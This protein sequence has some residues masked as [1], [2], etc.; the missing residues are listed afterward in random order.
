MVHLDFW[1]FMGSFIA[2]L[3]MLA[4]AFVHYVAMT[5]LAFLVNIVEQTSF[6]S[7]QVRVELLQKLLLQHDHL[8]HQLLEPSKTTDVALN[9]NELPF[10]L[11]DHKIEKLLKADSEL[12]EKTDS[13]YLAMRKVK[14]LFEVQGTKTSLPESNTSKSITV[15][16]PSPQ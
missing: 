9:K 2:L 3:F 7:F 13:W 5:Q 11:L 6:N 16:S 15:Y 8:Q 4:Y 12:A 10:A 14:N 1:V